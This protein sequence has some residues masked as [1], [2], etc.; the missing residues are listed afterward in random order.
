MKHYFL[1]KTT[2][3]EYSSS[4]KY[5]AETFEEAEK[6]ILSGKFNGWYCSTT[7]NGQ[8]VEV[9]ENFKVIH[10]H[11]YWNGELFEVD[12]KRVKNKK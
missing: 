1:V 7:G 6:Q 10:T 2:D 12:Y 5:I 3:N 9:D 11:D 8:V 4:Y